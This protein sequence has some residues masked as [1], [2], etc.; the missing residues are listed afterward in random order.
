MRGAGLVG[1]AYTQL[2]R[3]LFA[4]RVALLG[5][6]KQRKSKIDAREILDQ[7]TVAAPGTAL[8]QTLEQARF[9]L[10]GRR[11]A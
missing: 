9:D 3:I 4:E 7:L 8:A 1:R 10:N 6:A 5:L 11:C 2:D